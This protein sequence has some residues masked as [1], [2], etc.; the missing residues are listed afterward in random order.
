MRISHLSGGMLCMDLVTR[1]E[2]YSEEMALISPCQVFCNVIL[3][4]STVRANKQNSQAMRTFSY[5]AV[6]PLL[7]GVNSSDQDD[8]D[9]RG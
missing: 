2:D 7:T 1:Q 4:A 3:P 6:P 5:C 9:E 8:A